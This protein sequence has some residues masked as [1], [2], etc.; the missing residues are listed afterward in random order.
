MEPLVSL[1]A[2]IDEDVSQLRELKSKLRTSV[3]REELEKCI[4]GRVISI[5]YNP[6][7]SLKEVILKRILSMRLRLWNESSKYSCRIVSTSSLQSLCRIQIL[8]KSGWTCQK[9]LQSSHRNANKGKQKD[10]LHVKRTVSFNSCSVLVS[11][12]T[13]SYLYKTDLYW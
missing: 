5:P 11:V 7:R 12:F 4:Q 9:W 8:W 3:A 10:H 2:Q 6:K 1:Q 13:S